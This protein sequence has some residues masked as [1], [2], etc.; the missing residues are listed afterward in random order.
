MSGIEQDAHFELPM[1]VFPL[2]SGVRQFNRLT[3]SN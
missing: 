1:F 3:D 2:A